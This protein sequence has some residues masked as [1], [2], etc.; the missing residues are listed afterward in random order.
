GCPHVLGSYFLPGFVGDFMTA[1]PR[2]DLVLWTGSS[3]QVEAAVIAR[4]AQLGLV[5]H[6]LAH[7]DLVLVDL[8]ADQVAL[9]AVLDGAEP[10]TWSAAV[11]QLRARPLLYVPHV[12]QALEIVNQLDAR[13]LAP[14]RRLECGDVQL[15]KELALAG[16]GIAI[17]PRRVAAHG[18]P[19]R[20]QA[21]HP[22]LPSV[23]DT[24]RLVYRGD[25]QRTRA[26]TLVKDALVAHG[27]AVAA[28]DAG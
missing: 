18:Q 11:K 27:R 25:A 6:P 23:A 20:L 4:E 26:A 2:I 21:L 5:T 14:G 15:V 28:A 13:G 24:I 19:G 7:P 10:L 12:P 22:R 17:L 16:T 8:F 3:R 9:F 1:Y